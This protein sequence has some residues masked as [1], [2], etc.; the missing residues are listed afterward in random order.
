MTQLRLFKDIPPKEKL[1]TNLTTHR[2]PLHRWFNFIAGFSPEFVS[3]CIEAADLQK[4][5]VLIDPFAGLSTALAQANF[6]GVASVGF[7]AHPFF[8]DISLAKIFPPT[9]RQQVDAI[10][11]LA[12]SGVEPY[13]G[14]L[15]EIW[16]GDAAIFLGKLIP[17]PDLRLLASALLLENQLELPERPLYRLVLSKVL[18]YT[19]HAQTDGI[20]KAPTT[21]KVSTPYHLALQRACDEI[22]EDM[23]ALDGDYEQR[24]I[25]YPMSSEAMTP[26]ADESCSLCVTSPPYLNNFD[27]AE[28]TRM[29]LYFWRYAGSWAEITERVRRRLIVNTTTAPTALKR[30]QARFSNMLSENFCKNLRPLIE[31]LR[32][33]QK[34]RAGKKDY[35]SLVYPYFAQMQ[36]VIQ[37]LQRV[38]RPNSSLHMIV[39]DAALYGVYIQADMLLGQLLQENGFEILKIEKLRNRGDRWVLEKRQGGSK[40]GEFHIHARRTR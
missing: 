6:D 5:E 19:A 16:T 33:Q 23:A 12:L 15:T 13:R 9:Q 17:E 32:E 24:A 38:L 34:V 29:E 40:L 4:N 18:E 22:R 21:Q 10:Q 3:W 27:F 25:L 7:E 31:A 36:S 35:H 26:L 11:A 2:Y 37:E 1:S 28:M 30:D 14:E 39:G 8:Y 20:Y